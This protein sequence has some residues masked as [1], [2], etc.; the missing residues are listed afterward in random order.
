MTPAACSLI[1][2]DEAAAALGAAV[3]PPAPSVDPTEN[4]CSFG[5][6]DLADMINFVEIEVVNPVEFTPTRESVPD[7]FEITAAGGL[8]EAAYFQKDFLPNDSGTRM[9]LSVKKGQTVIRID[10]VLDG[11]TDDELKNLEQ[12][13]AVAALGRF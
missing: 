12:G 3:N 4:V 9:S 7:S 6:A 10:V 5:G 11:A 2:S 8:G 13:L 1:T